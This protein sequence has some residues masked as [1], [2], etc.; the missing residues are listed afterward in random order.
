MKRRELI[1]SGAGFVAAPGAALA[2]SSSDKPK[3]PL[4]SRVDSFKNWSAV[5]S[6]QSRK[7]D[8][9]LKGSYLV[10]GRATSSSF[11]FE[12]LQYPD[13]RKGSVAF[14]AAQGRQWGK[15]EVTMP[16]AKLSN[17]KYIG[18]GF[19]LGRI[20][21]TIISLDGKST[22]TY[23][24]TASFKSKLAVSA[25]LWRK[26]NAARTISIRTEV[27]GEAIAIM[28]IPT[29]GLKDATAAVK[30]VYNDH[31]STIL[32]AGNCSSGGG[33]IMTSASVEMLGRDDACFELEQMRRLR[34]AFGHE[35]DVLK[36]YLTT[37]A[38][39]LNTSRDWRFKLALVAFYAAVVW[40]T[41]IATR[42][43][44]FHTARRMYL[45][46]FEGF[47]WLMRR[48]LSAAV[49]IAA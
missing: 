3:L 11:Q 10:R 39:L 7:K 23:N 47:K 26:I 2:Q 16:A 18:D 36:D 5:A 45:G 32:A 14:S 22:A 40:P 8:E 49:P 35:A 24:N 48:R 25:A 42:L 13:V 20:G 30:R 28:S 9:A 41:A 15:V 19:F 4:C 17:G 43:G 1:M 31:K 46:G 29:D 38:Q 44:F 33:C 27:D 21:R 6:F 37:G 34:S 12:G